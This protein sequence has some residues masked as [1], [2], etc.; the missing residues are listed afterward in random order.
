MASLQSI[1]YVAPYETGT[2]RYMQRLVLAVLF[3]AIVAG[4]VALLFRGAK[5]MADRTGGTAA[6]TTGGSMQR[7]AFFLLLCLMIYVSVSGAS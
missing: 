2:T 4:L 5:E 1:P 6:F 7:V 3:L